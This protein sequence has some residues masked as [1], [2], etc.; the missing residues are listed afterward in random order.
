MRFLQKIIICCIVI[1]LIKPVI[2]NAQSQYAISLI[3]PEL[4]KNAKAVIRDSETSLTISSSSSA[5]LKIRRIIT[6]LDEDGR[7]LSIYFGI[8]DKFVTYRFN[9]LVI[10]DNNGKKVKGYGISDLE[11]QLTFLG[12][13]LY[14]DVHYKL[15]DT[16]FRTYPFTAEISYSVDLKGFFSFPDWIIAEDYNISTEKATLTITAPSDFNLRYLEQ[17]M[18]DKCVRSI[19][20]NDSIYKWKVENFKAIEE[21]PFSFTVGKISP[22]VFLAPADFEMAGRSGST[23]TWKEFGLFLAKLSE[24]RNLLSEETVTKVKEIA[25]SNPDNVE[26]IRKL[27]SFMQ[28]KTRYVSVQI[29]IGGWQPIEAEK[30]D[31][32]SYGDCKALSN[33]MKS[34]LDVAGIKSYYAVIK[35]GVDENNI[36][37]D[38]ASNQFNHAI[39][40]VPGATD[41][42]WLECTSQRIPFNY[43]GSFTDDRN[44]LLVTP[45]GGQLSRTRKYSAEENLMTR[46]ASVIIDAAGNGKASVNSAYSSLYYDE[47][48]PVLL[49]DYE[50][51]KRSISES[52]TI[53]GFTLLNFRINQPD[54]NVPLIKENL[55]ISIKGYASVMS[56]R[57]ILPLNLMNKTKKLPNS[58]KRVS[59]V[60]IQREKTL[61]DTIIYTIPPDYTISSTLIPVSIDSRFGTYNTKL[62]ARD[63]KIIYIRNQVIRKGTF[64]P[65]E[66]YDLADYINKIAT[67]DIVR[68]VLKKL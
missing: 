24:G 37:T 34:L 3:D 23:K 49:S 17:N 55:E 36:I 22:A 65:D 8:D 45:D 5:T 44:I 68:V 4:I 19:F 15:L 61:A 1:V 13:T 18:S 2:I 32:T 57:I 42:I 16:G 11:P 54:R 33:Y 60:F 26:K 29:G 47:K 64:L 53:P 50:D 30:V 38:F 48:M 9:D 6:V 46:C 56:D 21:E 63:N 25:A 39:L 27:Y 7:Y 58:I 41:T 10:Y 59:P 43:L 12:S 66:Y 67:A 35:A 62:E 40:C 31:K 51:Q 52:L 28:D 20:K 14:S